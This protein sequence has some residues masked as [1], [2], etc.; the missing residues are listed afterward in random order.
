MWSHFWGDLNYVTLNQYSM[1]KLLFFLLAI[2]ATVVMLQAQNTCVGPTNLTATPHVPDYRN[3]TLSWTP[4]SDPQSQTVALSDPMTLSTRIGWGSGNP[5][6]VVCVTRYT[7]SDLAAYHGHQFTDVLFAPGVASTFASF[8]VVVFKG[9]NMNP[10]DTS[11]TPGTMIY[12]QLV[13]TALT[14]GAINTIP[15]TAPITIDATQELWVGVHIVTIYGYPIYATTADGTQHNQNLVGNSTYTTWRP[16]TISGS[17][18]NWCIGMNVTNN[19]NRPQGYMVYRNSTPLTSTPITSTIF[20]DSVDVNGTF[21]YDVTAKY[22]NNCESTPITATIDMDD[23]TCLIYDLPFTENFDGHPGTTSGT[24][25]NLPECW[26]N[27]CGTYSSY[28]GYPIIYSGSSYSHSG[29][30]SLRFYTTTT[31]T[32]YGYQVAILPPVDIMSYPMNTLQIEFYGRASATSSNFN[33]VV[34]VMDNY[35]DL[36]TFVPIDTFSSSSTTHTEFITDFS[37][38]TGNGAYIALMAPRTFVSNYGYIDDIQVYEIPSCPKPRDI[39]STAATQTSITLVWSEMGSAN[40]WEVEYGPAGFRLG[41][42]TRVAAMTNPFTVT[43]LSSSSNYDFYVRA[44]CGYDDTSLVSGPFTAATECGYISQ[45]PY[46][47]NFDAFPGSTSTS[48]M[49]NLTQF[50]WSNINT[51][52]SYSNY[53]IAYNSST[54]AHSGV[55]ALRY[56]IYGSTAYSDQYAVMPALDPSISINTLMLEYKARPYSTSSSSYSFHVIIGVMS[57]STDV[58]TFVPVDTLLI[59]YTESLIFRDYITM[60]NNYNGS[61]RYIAF[62]GVKP[63]SSTGYN[64]G[65]I[66]DIKLTYIPSCMH[67]TS[68]E[69]TSYTSED[70]TVNWEPLG[71][72]TIWEVVVVPTGDSPESGIAQQTSDFPYTVSMLTPETQYDVYVRAYCGGTD[73]SSWEGPVTFRTRCAM[74]SVIPYEEHFDTYG[75]A[76]STS[77]TSP[78]P[79]PTCWTRYTDNTSP[80]PYISSTQ[81]V[82]TGALYFYSTSAYYSMAV[83]QPLDISSYPANSLHLS[84]KALKTSASYGRLQVGVMT[85]PDSMETFVLLKNIYSSDIP[86][87]TTWTDFD[88]ILPDNYPTPVYLAFKSPNELTTY[89]YLDDVVLDAVPT[90]SEPRYLSVSQIQGTSALLTWEEALY[91][92]PD[93]MVQ[94]SELGMDNWSSPVAVTGTTYMLSGLTPNTAYEVRVFSDCATEVSDTVS[95]TFLTTCLSGG[96]VTIGDGTTT[97]VYLP[98]YSLYNK[99]YSQQIYTASELGG[100]NTFKSISFHMANLSQ[101]RNFSIY[102]MHTNVST[103]SDWLPA[104]NAQLV[105]TGPQTLVA[106]S[107]NTFNFSTPFVY[108]GTD[109]LVVI[110]IDENSSYTSG[111]SWYVHTAPAGSGA[112]KYTY[113]DNTSYSIT[114]VPTTTNG[115]TVATRNNVKFGAECDS[116]WVCVRPNVYVS[117]VNNTDVTINWAPGDN[118][119]SWAVEYK[120]ATDQNWTSEGT[121]STNTYTFSN[122]NTGTNYQFRVCALCSSTDSSAW[123][124]VSAFVPCSSISTL[125]YTQDFESATGS[126]SSH[127]VD[128]CL[129]RGTNSSTAYPYPSSTYS[130]GGTYALYFYGASSV[131]SYLALPKI[132]ES[133][134][135][136][137]LLVQFQ[138]LK[139]SAAYYV[140]AGI[141][142]DPDDIST[143]TSLATFSPSLTS[144][145]SNQNWEMGEFMTNTYTGT[146]RYIAFRIPQAAT[147]YIYL[148]DIFVDYLPSCLHVTNLHTT[149]I[150]STTAEIAWTPGQDEQNWVYAFGE[151]DSVD[152]TTA[153]LLT[154]TTN[155][156]SLTGLEPNTEYEIYLAADCNEPEPS[157]FMVLRFRTD[158]DPISTIPYHA[159]FDE[160]GGVS[161]TAYYP[162]CWYRHNTY[163]TT[164]QYPYLSTSYSTS[165]PQSIYFYSS[166]TATPPTYSLAITN[167]LAS[168]INIQTLQ[169]RF[170]LRATGSNYY[171]IVGVVTDPENPNSFTP[172]DTVECSATSTWEEFAIPLSG[173]AGQGRHIAFKGYGGFYF[174]DLWIEEIPNCDAPTDIVVNGITNHEATISWTEGSSETAWEV[175]VFPIDA[176]MSSATPYQVQNTPTLNLT[177]LNVATKYSVYVRAICPNGGYSSYVSG[178]FTTL[179]DPM[180]TIPYTENFDSYQ[181]STSST[182]NNLPTCWSYINGGASYPGYPIIYNSSVYAESGTNSLR[183]YMFTST[184]YSDQYAIMPGLDVTT[185]PISGL[186]LKFDARQ[187][188]ASYPFVLLVG[189]MSDPADATTFELVDSLY[190]TND[191]YEPQHV[192]FDNYAG[193]GSYIAFKAPKPQTSW[194]FNYNEGHVD[195]IVLAQAS[196][197]RPA[198]NLQFSNISTSTVD[199]SWDTYGTATSWEIQYRELNGTDTNWMV[200][201]AYGT[202]TFQLM[203]LNANTTYEVM[204]RTDCGGGEY[205]AWSMSKVFTT[206]CEPMTTIPFFTN[207]DSYTGTTSGT[208]NNLPPCWHHLQ[209]GTVSTYAGYPIIYNNSTYAQSGANSLR[210]YTYTTSTYGDEYAILPPID[211]LMH[212]INSLQVEFDVRKYS[213]SYTSFLLIVGVM[214]DPYD[215]NTFVALDS[216]VAVETTY[217]SHT[218][219]LNNY[220]GGGAYIALKGPQFGGGTYNE[221]NVDNLSISQMPLCLPVRNVTATNITPNSA[222]ISWTPNGSEPAW[223]VKYQANTAGAVADSVHVNTPTCSLSN[224]N[225][226]TIYTVQVKADCGS[227]E[228]SPYSDPTMFT[229]ECL[230]ISTLPYTENF[231]SYTQFATALTAPAGYPDIQLPLCWSFLNMSSTTSTYPQVFLT[232]ST[233]YAVSGKCLFFKSSS[234]TPLYAVLPSFTENARNL[235]ITFTYRN[236]GTT[237]SNGTLSVG[238]M[239]DPYDANTYV[240]VYSCPQTTTKTQVIQAFNTIPTTANGAYI[241]FRYSGGSANNYY[242]SIDNVTVDMMPCTVPESLAVSNI[243]ANSANV[244]WTPGGGESSWNLQYKTA[245]A[246]SWT[247]VS[248]LTSPSYTLTNLQAT[249]AYLVRVQANC[250]GDESDWTSPVSFTTMD[251]QCAAP[252]NLHLVDTTSVTAILDWS[253]TAGS[254]NEWT[255]YFRKNTEDMWSMQTTTTHP[256]EVTGLEPNTT[257]VAQVT[258]HC[259]NGM[260][261][262]PSNQITFTTAIVGVEDYE[263]NMTEIYPN[264]TTGQFRIENSELR[265]QNVEVYD[266]YGKLITS[267]MVDDHSTVIDLSDNASG[268]YFTRIFTDKG[269]ITKRIV[270]K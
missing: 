141:M 46:I 254:A 166:A 136:D 171:M 115:S 198:R 128:P 132:D 155:P 158:C 182:V 101:Q 28:A 99:G 187:Y 178:T 71:D 16:L 204:V 121:V 123:S 185:Q 227:G 267:V 2:F 169:A 165:A 222:D 35:Y 229:T 240:E 116:D 263:L 6:N 8:E 3:V 70:V 189:V 64:S 103:A 170:Q 92:T 161:G 153:V 44:V 107:W 230:P 242:A 26:H 84:F 42:G 83:S 87:L 261:S 223:W 94:Y 146:G 183:F 253:Q 117:S 15:L 40:E 61:G 174:D 217:V 81:H 126:G 148:D 49:T 47:Q 200:Y 69:V 238:Y 259:T 205:S 257:Y 34:G 21:Q 134:Q 265:I 74:T 221:G 82:G 196:N 60:F 33:V 68:V 237:A 130:H 201:P 203:N 5:A 98:S 59:P 90:C 45:L 76:T 142:E 63:S 250:G 172:I 78:G 162:H 252:T 79:M 145:T 228:E 156:L 181:G 269:M 66:D 54:Y 186:E 73:Y 75:T 168:S 93:Y 106:N 89:V 72:E 177:N 55:N 114:S 212:P 199:V 236:E 213:T 214:S 102:L 140:E 218:S 30:N 202:P 152:V 18:Y 24:T 77:A 226:S 245:S 164:S 150:T 118:E 58:N 53:P 88:V 192:Y 209:T 109:N 179:C 62:R 188:T 19:T 10:L 167:E 39:A 11:F 120:M 38:Y 251:D 207:F 113:N 225:S 104:T 215:V 67:P 220:P 96:S 216:I 25:N 131:Y 51:G 234:T 147:S 20:V 268:V 244:T 247:L 37:Q 86:S 1:K 149:D 264:P 4:V 23:D 157:Q 191:E 95:K 112:A 48:G 43:G 143:F 211:T 91:G 110:V 119:N 125:P 232:S 27:I 197:C 7:T 266:V 14:A 190:L 122:L 176:D 193:T 108:N 256:Y 270:K 262:E 255:V 241:A 17:E 235:Q 32:D 195:N 29:N 111:N 124:S 248:N 137:S 80:Y 9:G 22:A 233:T 210:F 50:C 180:N 260:F 194:G 100:P 243:T 208:E 52:S 173:Y 206:E 249:T 133:I 57:D 56:Y 144:T 258:A 65:T 163:S 231:D 13:T 105:Y 160:Y 138:A 139:T 159:N 224:L 41:Q 129:T 154:T 246:S 127:T 85:N 97:N 12:N 175:Y 219:Y 239:T 36:N 31:S 151:R 135:I 184:S